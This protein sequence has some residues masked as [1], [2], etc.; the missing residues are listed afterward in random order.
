MDARG[1]QMTNLNKEINSMATSPHNR[2]YIVQTQLGLWEV[3]D[4]YIGSSAHA[5]KVIST[6]KDELLAL[7]L[8]RLAN[9]AWLDVKRE[10]YL[11]QNY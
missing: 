10:Q 9:S 4:K 2:Y 7:K 3:R 6:H 1:R 8:C 5:T 11:V